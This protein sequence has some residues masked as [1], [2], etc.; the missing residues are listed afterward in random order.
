[1]NCTRETSSC[2]YTSPLGTLELFSDGSGLCGARLLKSGFI[3]AS[4]PESVCPSPLL[5]QAS[6]QLDEY[7]SGKRQ[8][9]TVPLS[10]HGTAFQIEV[11]QALQNI[12]YG[13]TLSYGQL[14]KTI[15]RPRAGRAVGQA[16]HCNPILLFVPCHR[17]VGAKGALVG[18]AAGLDIKRTLLDMEY[19]CISR[20]LR[21]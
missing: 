15:G 6:L 19:A 9:F 18:F 2:F 4:G 5:A 10:L 17:A 7:F 16:C 8:V 1:M 21:V 11:W 14:A 3:P 12:P 13:K 20:S